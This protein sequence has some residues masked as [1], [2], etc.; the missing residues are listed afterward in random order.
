MYADFSATVGGNRAHGGAGPTGNGRA[1]HRPVAD[2]RRHDAVGVGGG[3]AAVGP[4]AVAGQ[5]DQRQGR[6]WRPMRGRMSVV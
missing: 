1:Q 3:T 6:V 2:R 5:I 4:G